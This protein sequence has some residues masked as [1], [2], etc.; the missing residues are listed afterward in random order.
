METV[1]EENEES[2]KK[3]V[4]DEKESSQG[5]EEANEEI[6]GEESFEEFSISKT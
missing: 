6:I 4:V 1:I 3:P 2:V 5:T